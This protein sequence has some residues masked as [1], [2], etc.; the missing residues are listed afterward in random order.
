MGEQHL[1]QKPWSD[2]E[3][4]HATRCLQSKQD[5]ELLASVKCTHAEES[6]VLSLQRTTSSEENECTAFRSGE[7]LLNKQ[8]ADQ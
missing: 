2:T 5:N 8:N 6:S 3:C 1:D 7:M 4:V